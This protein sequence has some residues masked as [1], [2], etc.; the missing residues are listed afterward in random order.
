[1]S[2]EEPSMVRII[3]FPGGF[4]WPLWVAQARGCFA[5]Q[6]VRV[7]LIPTPGSVFQWQCLADGQA[8]MA[9][10]L[11]DN[12]VAYREGQGEIDLT[13][14]D[15]VAL[16]T[17]DTRRMP[18]LVVRPDITSFAGLRGETLSVD[19]L[20][21]GLVP[22]L[23]GMLA[24]GGL[25]GG[26]YRLQSVGGVLQRYEAL[27]AH[28][29]AGALFNSPFDGLLRAAGFT[30]L[31]N[32]RDMVA[33]YQGQVLAARDGWVTQHH[34]AAAGV[35]RAILDGLAWLYDPANKAAACDIFAAAMPGAA[36]AAEESYANLFDGTL[37]FV[38][39]GALDLEGVGEVIAMRARYRAPARPFG[40]A[41]AYC[42][43]SCWQ[44]AT[45]RA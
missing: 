7:E 24:Q 23:A 44:E 11:M 20:A 42:R 18:S 15:A 25:T 27:L 31:A 10:T 3:V 32:G 22:L 2:A 9:V 26:D 21:T 33:H 36:A 39:D 34:A 13:V 41:M 28:A 1:M 37:G 5:A 8:D 12:I 35:L 19:S 45:E 14:P 17:M 4:N 43:L 6:G 16:M 40:D 29:Q 38:R 30:V